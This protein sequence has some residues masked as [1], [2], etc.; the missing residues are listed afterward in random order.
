VKSRNHAHVCAKGLGRENPFKLALRRL[1]EH[2]RQDSFR[3]CG[4]T[5][6]LNIE[7]PQTMQCGGR[8]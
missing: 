1:V 2:V 6:D 8:A 7:Q 4:T 5:V 3:L